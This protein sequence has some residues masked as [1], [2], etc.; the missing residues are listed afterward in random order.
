M[1][2]HDVLDRELVGWFSEDATRRAPARL[3][4]AIVAD[5]RTRPQQPGWLV[6]LRGEA[7]GAGVLGRTRARRASLIIAVLA[8]IA[9]IAALVAGG[10]PVRPDVRLLAFIRNG[11]VYIANEDGSG[12]RLTLHRNGVTF[13]TVAWSPDGNRLAVDNQAAY[14]DPDPGVVIVDVR[15]GAMSLVGDHNPVWSPDGRQL[16]VLYEAPAGDSVGVRIRFVDVD[17]LATR[18]DFPFGASGG[19]AWSPNGRW[20]AA[21]GGGGVVRLDVVSGQMVQIDRPSGH[22]EV[23]K[24]VTWAPDSRHIAFVRY[25]VGAGRPLRGCG[26]NENCDLAVFVADAD[27][28]NLSRVSR[29]PESADLPLWSPDGTWLAFRQSYMNL[30][31][32]GPGG[33]GIAIVRA[34]VTDERTVVTAPVQG[35]VWST[36]GDRLRYAMWKGPLGTSTI[37]ETSIGGEAHSLGVVVDTGSTPFLRTGFGFAWQVNASDQT[38]KR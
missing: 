10:Q 3:L 35:F 11:D 22:L 18:A 6:T 33:Y 21:T 7:M 14:A 9:L 38:T 19:L 15:S 13:V 12:A 20:I 30:S 16:A 23:P 27:G 4:D 17:T 25:W 31:A 8:L 2:H 28:S 26:D 29:W 5:T 37:W 24:D 1:T 32:T 34:D 36:S